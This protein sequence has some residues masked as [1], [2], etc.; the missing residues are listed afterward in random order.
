VQVLKE[1]SL[2]AAL[3][4]ELSEDYV[5]RAGGFAAL[6]LSSSRVNTMVYDEEKPRFDI[7]NLS[8]IKPF[9]HHR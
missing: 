1:D 3:R 4:P 2:G 7:I 9:R 5:C 6:N 8:A